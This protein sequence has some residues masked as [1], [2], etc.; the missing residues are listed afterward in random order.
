MT[1]KTLSSFFS[2]V[3]NPNRKKKR[4][5]DDGLS[6]APRRRCSFL[7]L[8]LLSKR[9]QL[10]RLRPGYF[11]CRSNASQIA[12]R[13][14]L[15]SSISWST[16]RTSA[17]CV[18]SNLNHVMS[19]GSVRTRLTTPTWCRR[20]PSTL[21]WYWTTRQGADSTPT[22]TPQKK[23]GKRKETCWTSFFPCYGLVTVG[24]EQRCHPPWINTVVRP[25]LISL[26]WMCGDA[27]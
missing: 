20:L 17:A 27:D 5:R 10:C 18:W 7:S 2:H 16:Q 25:P 14:T 23:K 22:P 19:Q 15:S 13:N 11:Y 9:K 24:G 12:A 21:G 1:F 8:P 26:C 4:R 6:S 3:F